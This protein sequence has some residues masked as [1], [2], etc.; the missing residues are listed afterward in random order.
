MHFM[1]LCICISVC[2]LMGIRNVD[3]LFFVLTKKLILHINVY[4][5]DDSIFNIKIH[6]TNYFIF[7]ITVD[8]DYD[9]SNIQ[10]D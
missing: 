9:L 3:N 4:F 6:K 1:H 8:Y 5:R 10:G 2:S 7:Y